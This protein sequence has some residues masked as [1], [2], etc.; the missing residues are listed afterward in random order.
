[1]VLETYTFYSAA[2]DRL[3]L[4]KGTFT[5]TVIVENAGGNVKRT[6]PSLGAREPNELQMLCR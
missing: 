1:V 6:G 4:D 3:G 2:K 5:I